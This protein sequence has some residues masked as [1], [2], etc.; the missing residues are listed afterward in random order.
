MVLRL[1]FAS[2]VEG[3]EVG[4]MLIVMAGLPGTGKSTLAGRLAEALGGVVLDKDAVRAT[5]FPRPVLDYSSEQ[6][7]VT[8]TAVYA[9]A[10]HILEA[11]PARAV[12]LDG[13]TFS[14][15]H[16]FRDLLALA[17]SVRQ[18]PVVLECVCDDEVAR[19]RLERDLLRGEHPAG[20][21]TFA[22][23]LRVRASAEPIALPHLTLDT[24]RLSSDECLALA[25]A[26]VAPGRGTVPGRGGTS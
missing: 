9:A 16:Q 15:A 25:L 7:E 13:R 26:Y 20:N 14:R 4:K 21:R 10:R 12:L 6:D 5:L 19:R 18:P 22:L 11:D 17:V 3:Y 24:D 23:Y 2:P 1:L 8:M